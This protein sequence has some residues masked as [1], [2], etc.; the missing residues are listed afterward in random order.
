MIVQMKAEIGVIYEVGILMCDAIHNVRQDELN[1]I[2]LA[3]AKVQ[4]RHVRR[5]GT[6]DFPYLGTRYYM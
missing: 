1:S 4:L 3:L 5:V 2:M 6:P